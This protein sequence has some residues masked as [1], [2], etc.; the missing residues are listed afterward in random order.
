MMSSWIKFLMICLIGSVL[1]IGLLFL[2]FE[3]KP[4]IHGRHEV[5][6][7]AGSGA[8]LARDVEHALERL[9]IS[10]REVDE[11]FIK[12]GG[13]MDCSALI[14]PGGYTASYVST[15]GK[16]GFNEIRRFVKGGGLYIG[17]CAGA[18]IAA[19]R[20]EVEGRPKGLGIIDIEN[21]RRRGMGLVKITITNMSH[22]LAEGCPKTMSTWYQNGPYMKPGKGVEVIARYDEEYAAIV[23]STYGHGRVVIFSPHPEGSLERGVDPIKSGTAKLLKNALT[24]TQR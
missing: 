1:T 4:R 20:V 19:E 11:N 12:S 2:S 8:V 14:I 3:R 21:V 9:G 7:Y 23:C 18:Y 17:I 6:V 13:L 15:L 16:D 10:Y 24:L 22:P 5:C